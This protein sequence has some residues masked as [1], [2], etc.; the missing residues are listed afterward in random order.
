MSSPQRLIAH[1]D[2]DSFYASAEMKRH[3]DIAEMPVIIGADPKD[4]RGRGVV[5]SCNY[6]A[7]RFGVRSAMPI[8]EAWRLCPQACYLRPDFEY[9]ET[10]SAE[11]MQLIRTRVARFEQVSIDEAFID[12]T[13][14]VT[15]VE[16]AEEWVRRLKAEMRAATGLTCSIGLA[17]NKSA[18]KIAT[19]L[20]KPDGVTTIPPDETKERLGPLQA[21]VIPGVGAKT[22]V[23]L[24][25][26]GVK[27]VGDLQRLDIDLVKRRLGR[28]GIWLWEVANG[29]ERED[30][31][32]HE[33]KSLST[34]RTFEEDTGDWT[35]VE[36]V[37]R[38][39]ATELASRAESAH[40]LFRRAGIKVRFRGFETHTREARL[41]TFS[42]DGEVLAKEV[43][44]LLRQFRSGTRPVRL[45]GIRIS[46]LKR[47]ATDQA[48]LTS[49]I[50]RRKTNLTGSLE[51]SHRTGRD[52]IL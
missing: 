14:V 36:S 43:L 3:P 11:V 10:L 42:R 25:E 35:L 4:G 44:S 7:R 48:T 41:A 29:M 6:A 15:S 2:M 39:L 9:Y 18:A 52:E 46:E 51:D 37:A 1:I 8:S 17:V 33:L 16:D 30:V 12:L 21:T 5:V 13:G 49:W 32:E 38:E 45:V 26:L 20:H 28:T 27:T 31:A 22:A 23:A 47:E 34:E 40:L 50:D 19:D 24:R